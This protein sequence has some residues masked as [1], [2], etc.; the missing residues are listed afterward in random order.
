MGT[1]L[2]TALVMCCAV[3][4]MWLRMRAAS[5]TASPLGCQVVSILTST[6]NAPFCK[7][8]GHFGISAIS[9]VPGRAFICVRGVCDLLCWSSRLTGSLVRRESHQSGLACAFSLASTAFSVVLTALIPLKK[10]PDHE[11]KPTKEAQALEEVRQ[12]KEVVV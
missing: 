12:E 3:S 10:L 4:C 6:F 2:R 7:L 9:H 11:K 5:P 1:R 8:L